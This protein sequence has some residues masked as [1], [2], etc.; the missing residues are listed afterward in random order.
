MEIE[1][2]AAT[3]PF[4]EL[5][6]QER[7]A[8]LVEMSS[9]EYD[10][11]HVLLCTARSLDATVA[12][13]PEL[14]IRLQASMSAVGHKQKPGLRLLHLRLPAWQAAAAVVLA[15]VAGYFCRGEKPVAEPQVSVQTVVQHDTV[16]QERRV[17]KERV[18]VRWRNVEQAD[19]KPLVVAP[20]QD[21]G[22]LT[23]ISPEPVLLE[24]PA[25]S[26]GV[27]LGQQPE[28]LQFFTRPQGK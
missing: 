12:P 23:G 19:Q 1:S 13:P 26:V 4:A 15:L 20:E 8:V 9:A 28:L 14:G 21:E 16:F 11:L 5:D 24:S 27:P 3:R 6:P 10:R 7:A 18:V 17:W 2:L 22:V 25:V